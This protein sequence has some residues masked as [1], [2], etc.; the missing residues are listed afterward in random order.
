MTPVRSERIVASSSLSWLSSSWI[1]CAAER[2]PV[3]D[4]KTARVHTWLVDA[5][6]ECERD[7]VHE[8][9]LHALDGTVAL[10]LDAAGTGARAPD[11]KELAVRVGEIPVTA[12]SPDAVTNPDIRAWYA[13]EGAPPNWW[14]ALGHDA[15]IL[16]RG[17]V[18]ALPLD[19]TSDPAEVGKRRLAAKQALAAAQA[20]LWTSEA[21]GFS[22]AHVI[23]REAKVVELGPGATKAPGK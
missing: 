16:A 13:R 19:A 2:A 22:A 6:S 14:A 9:S 12:T 4:W 8:L 7:L 17:A 5:P 10:T 21:R 1:V 15:A 23:V 3:A 11:V 18:A 20:P